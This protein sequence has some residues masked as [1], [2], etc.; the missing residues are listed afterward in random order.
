MKVLVCLDKDGCFDVAKFSDRKKC[1]EILQIHGNY[2]DEIIENYHP[3]MVT[4]DVLY[5]MT[6][7]KWADF[8]NSF[9]QRG[10]YQITT[11]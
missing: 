9:S 8:V 1:L 6:E 7:D 11:L 2:F 5:Y 4:T 3:D 10:M